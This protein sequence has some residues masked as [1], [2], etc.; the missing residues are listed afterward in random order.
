MV[1]CIYRGVTCYPN[2]MT[3]MYFFLQR[4]RISEGVDRGGGGGTEIEGAGSGGG[5]GGK[6]G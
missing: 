4:T 2:K 6:R 3:K 5:G 1:H